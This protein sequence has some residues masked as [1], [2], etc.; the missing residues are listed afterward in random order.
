[1]RF[2][3]APSDVPLDGRGF[4]GP[5]AAYLFVQLAAGRLSPL[6]RAGRG[7]GVRRRSKIIPDMKTVAARRRPIEPL[8][9][10][11]ATT[12]FSPI[13]EMLGRRYDFT[14]D[15]PVEH[16]APRQALNAVLYGDSE[17]LTINLSEFSSS[18]RQPHG[19]VGGRWPN[20]SAAPRTTTPSTAEK[21]REQ[22]LVYR[23][24]LQRLRRHRA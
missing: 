7:G 10:V 3:S 20:T 18:R 9:H 15:D 16:A 14:L 2:Y 11:T 19:V 22:F 13:L 5:R 17:P 23:K 21:W 24:M 6:Q 1:M 12:C 8:G 4:R